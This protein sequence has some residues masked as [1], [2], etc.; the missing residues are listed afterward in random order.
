MVEGPYLLDTSTVIWALADPELL[1]TTARRVPD[2]R[3]LI[4]QAA[5]E[6]LTLVTSDKQIQHYAVKTVW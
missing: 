2:S 1:S 6:G 4:A 5:A 3:M